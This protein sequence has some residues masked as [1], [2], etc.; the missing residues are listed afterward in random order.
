MSCKKICGIYRIK[1][2]I[3]NKIYIGES[4]DLDSRLSN[5]KSALKTGHHINKHL[6]SAYNKYGEDNFE[7]KIIELCDT[8]VRFEK[9]IYWIAFY[10]S[11]YNGYNMTIGGL[12]PRFVKDFN[13]KIT[14]THWHT[15]LSEDDVMNI[16]DKLLEGKSNIEIA[17]ELGISQAIVTNIRCHKSWKHLTEELTFDK[18]HPP[19]RDFSNCKLNCK[20]D[21]YYIDGTFVDSFCSIHDASNKLKCDYRL[22]SSVCYGKRNNTNGYVFRFSGHPFDEY[23]PKGHAVIAV[24]QYDM[25]WNYIRSYN[26][27]KEVK[28]LTGIRIDACIQGRNKSAGGY[29]WLRHGDKPPIY[30]KP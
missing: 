5:H 13:G 27:Q 22:V 19:K 17:N 28:Q 1:N 14:R 29:Y 3:N 11:F 23:V 20:V 9:E 8:S 4:I 24:D 21:A 25:N 30:K 6:Q 18:S 26:S 2:L 16:I 10:D 15:N 12:D 7:F